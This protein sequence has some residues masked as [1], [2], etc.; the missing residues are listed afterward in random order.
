LCKSFLNILSRI[1]FAKAQGRGR[2][3]SGLK[4]VLEARYVTVATAVTDEHIQ[5]DF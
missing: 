4:D 3:V 2:V 1:Q 5:L